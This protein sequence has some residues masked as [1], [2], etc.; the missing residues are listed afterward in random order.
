[1]AQILKMFHLAQQHGV[2]QMQIRRGRIEA[3][4]HA[5]GPARLGR[6]Q[7]AFAQVLFANDLDQAFLQIGQLFVY[8]RA[9]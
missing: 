8:G 7:Q 1:M 4:F 2:A 9:L 3:R 5:Q 6:L